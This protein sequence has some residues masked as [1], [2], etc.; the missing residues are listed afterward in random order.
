M[1]C[2]PTRPAI[3]SA[4]RSP[5]ATSS[6]ATRCSRPRRAAAADVV[7]PVATFLEK[8]GTFT[9]SDRRFQR[10]RP[11]LA[12][13]RQVRDDFTVLRAVARA[14][15]TDLGCPTPAATLD[16]CAALSPLFAGVSHDRLAAAGL[17]HWPCRSAAAPGEPPLHPQRFATPSGRAV[18]SD[19]PWLLRG[20][21]PISTIRLFSSPA[22][23]SSTTTRAA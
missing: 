11:A 8:N 9:N 23:D 14:L 15:G 5:C 10:V 12:P 4:A 13:P 6:S 17:L 19:V 3:G 16:E 20:R 7:L 18:L 2:R 22:D 21:S 1:C